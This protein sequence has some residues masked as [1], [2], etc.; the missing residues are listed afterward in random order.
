MPDQQTPDTPTAAQ[1]QSPRHIF[2]AL[3][4]R[5]YRLFFIGQGIS[6][7]GT[8]TQRVAMGW[9]VY[10]LTN[11]EMLLGIVGFSSMIL[12][13]F[14]S[15]VAGVLA[16]RTDKKRLLIITQCVSMIQAFVLAG[17]TL[18]GL[19]T[20]PWIIALSAILGFVNSFDVPIRQSFQ[21][22]MVGTREDL[23]NAIAL[24]SFIFHGS[25]LIGPAVAGVLISLVGEG[26]CFLINAISFVTVLF[27]LMAIRTTP[28]PS[29]S[30]G[31]HP[32]QTL[33]EGF[34]YAY[35]FL[36]IRAILAQ[37]ALS[38]LLGMG[39]GVLMPVFAR[40]I[41]H[42]DSRTMG[43]LMSASGM[44]AVIGTIYLA[45]RRSP[46]GLGTIIASGGLIYGIVTIAFAL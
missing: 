43:F 31:V 27:A 26:I 7:M 36:P 44:G 40:D 37:L 9:L 20:V 35:G 45:S 11:S 33:K 12:S 32:L 41:L 39:L 34:Q 18:S 14:F 21:V 28:R 15:P 4:H 13:F 46:Q 30:K 29:V 6:L 19:I 42:G 23:P 2:R 3:K 38:S 22:E 1:R 8:W 5:N 24:N 16:D 10:R 17:L 25:K